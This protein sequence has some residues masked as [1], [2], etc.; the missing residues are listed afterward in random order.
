MCKE[1]NKVRNMKKYGFLS[2]WCVVM[3]ACN[4]FE[5]RKTG[6]D[7]TITD[8]VIKID[9]AAAMGDSV[10]NV[11]SVQIRDRFAADGTRNKDTVLLP[12]SK[13]I[14]TGNTGPDEVVRFAETLVG[15]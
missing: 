5:V 4:L 15:T 9:S 2:L 1:Q 14:N 7:V 8:S 12:P 3:G 11:D 13:T 6:T 10:L